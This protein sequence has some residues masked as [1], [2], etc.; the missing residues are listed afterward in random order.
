M[1]IFYIILII[2]ILAGFAI[3]GFVTYKHIQRIVEE[4]QAAEVKAIQQMDIECHSHCTEPCTEYCY[5]MKKEVEKDKPQ[6]W[7]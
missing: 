4:E 3:G 6:L 7:I 5:G 2:V 1:E